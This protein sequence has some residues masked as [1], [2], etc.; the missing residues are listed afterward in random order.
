M[1]AKLIFTHLLPKRCKETLW[2]AIWFPQIPQKKFKNQQIKNKCMI[3][4]SNR[5]TFAARVR[6]PIVPSVRD[7]IRRDV[8]WLDILIGF[9]KFLSTDAFLRVDFALDFKSVVYLIAS[10]KN[11]LS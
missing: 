8:V 1:A 9:L 5:K 10:Y 11:L 7:I 3:T 6:F 2:D 4:W